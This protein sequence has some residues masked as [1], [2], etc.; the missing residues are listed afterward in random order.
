MA[1]PN[2]NTI[3]QGILTI[4]NNLTPVQPNYVVNYD[5]GNPTASAKASFFDA[6]FIATNGLA[7]GVN[8]PANLKCYLAL[9]QNTSTVNGVTVFPIWPVSGLTQ[10]VL[11]PGGVWIFY[12]V[13][14]TTGG[15]AGLQGLELEGNGADVVCVVATASV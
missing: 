12:D 13:A 3:L 5:V 4:N 6:G 15:S 2:F 1:T 11:G 14:Q 8:L 7:A 9:V 10:F